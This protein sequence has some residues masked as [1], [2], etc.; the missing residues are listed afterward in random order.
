M[1]S[2]MV[3]AFADSAHFVRSTLRSIEMARDVA[4]DT[5]QAKLKHSLI[6]LPY[7][8]RGLWDC[9]SVW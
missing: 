7:L 8:E 9:A 5:I 3:Y 1:I 6:V 4:G 2:V